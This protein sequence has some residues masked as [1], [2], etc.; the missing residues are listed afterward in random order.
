MR[1]RKLA[2]E[3]GDDK[4]ITPKA[5]GEPPSTLLARNIGNK[6][7]KQPCLP[8]NELTMPLS[9]EAELCVLPGAQ[10]QRSSSPPP[11]AAVAVATSSSKGGGG[12]VEGAL[13]RGGVR[14]SGRTDACPAPFRACERDLEEDRFGRLP[15]PKAER[16]GPGCWSGCC[17]SCAAYLASGS[18]GLCKARRGEELLPG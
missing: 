10:R 2:S 11:P 18:S 3:I 13:D 16:R 8:Q 9:Q 1:V 14:V 6:V 7:R 4:K 17:T 15:A 12:T 5:S